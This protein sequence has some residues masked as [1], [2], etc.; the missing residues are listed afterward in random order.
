M[1][2]VRL[3]KPQNIKLLLTIS[4]YKKIGRKQPAAFLITKDI[5]LEKSD[6]SFLKLGLYYLRLLFSGTVK[7]IHKLG[8]TFNGVTDYF[9][10]SNRFNFKG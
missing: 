1:Q 3:K 2:E 10:Y 9:F 4:S 7:L 6:P 8:D 5:F